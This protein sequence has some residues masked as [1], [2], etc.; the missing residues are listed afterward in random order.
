LAPVKLE[1]EKIGEVV[2]CVFC[3]EVFKNFQLSVDHLKAFHIE[4][5]EPKFEEFSI[6]NVVINESESSTPEVK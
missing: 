5:T 2:L 3:G 6:Q 1:V 4:I